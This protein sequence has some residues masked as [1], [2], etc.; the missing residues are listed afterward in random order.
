MKNGW[1]R[2]ILKVLSTGKG[3][4]NMIYKMEY[5]DADRNIL[6][7]ELVNSDDDADRVLRHSCEKA[8][9]R[10]EQLK[11]R[12]SEKIKD[13]SPGKFFYEV[14]GQEG[15]VFSMHGDEKIVV[16]IQIVRLLDTG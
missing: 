3:T 1:I 14:T 15:T 8:V 5:L 9:K 13:V 10:Y 2:V 12:L 11:Q 16:E 4:I 7:T 6:M